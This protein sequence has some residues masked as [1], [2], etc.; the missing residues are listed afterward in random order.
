MVT[1]AFLRLVENLN[2]ITFDPNTKHDVKVP[3][4]HILADVEVVYEDSEH[5]GHRNSIMQP[6]D[7]LDDERIPC[8]GLKRHS[9]Q[10]NRQTNQISVD[11]SN[12]T[13]NIT[14]CLVYKEPHK[15]DWYNSNSTEVVN[16]EH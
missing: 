1:K 10:W 7:R 12:G 4:S 13:I 8:L 15:V 11:S 3:S 16:V 14:L 5:Q 9:V 6:R 2:V